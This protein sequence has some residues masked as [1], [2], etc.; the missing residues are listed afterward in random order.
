MIKKLD[1]CA[2]ISIEDLQEGLEYS[3]IETVTES[4]MVK[5]YQLSGDSNPLHHSDNFAQQRGFSSRVV[6][7]FLLSSYISKMVGR[8]LP[9]KNCL[10]LG[11]NLKFLAPCYIGDTVEVKAVVSQISVAVASAVLIMTITNQSTGEVLVKG[12]TTVGFTRQL[13]KK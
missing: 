9:G 8:F 2:E 6:F 3:F 10:L 12:K 4:E 5:F 7:G 11:S 1:L 13:Q